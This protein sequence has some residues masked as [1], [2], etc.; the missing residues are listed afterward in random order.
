MISRVV[1]KEVLDMADTIDIMAEVINRQ[2][3]NLQKLNILL[4]DVCKRLN[5][6]NPSL[7]DKYSEFNM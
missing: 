5:P 2:D 4:L 6:S 3:Q 1:K 7:Y